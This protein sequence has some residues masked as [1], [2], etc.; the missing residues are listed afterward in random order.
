MVEFEGLCR[1]GYYCLLGVLK[2]DMIE[3]FVG[4]YCIE[5]IFELELCFNG[6]FRNIIKGMFI[7]DCFNC[8]LGYY[9]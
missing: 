4:V 3:C 6:I 7:N 8:I 2:L 9:C 1:K 5:G